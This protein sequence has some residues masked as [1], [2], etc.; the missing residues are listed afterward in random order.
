MHFEFLVEE[1]SIEAALNNML[2]YILPSS[3]TYAIRVFQG[4]QDLLKK[5]PV[6]LSG[7]KRWIPEDYRIVI[8]VD[9]D[10]DDCLRLKRKLE[11]IALE[12]QFTTKSSVP[13]FD[14]FQVLNR[15]VI[16]ELESWFFGNRRAI[17]TAYPKISNNFVN[18]PRIINPD[19][20]SD[21]WKKLE[22]VLQRYRYYPQGMPKIEVA[23]NISLHMDPERNCSPSFQVFRRGLDA[24][25]LQG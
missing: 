14:S 18:K 8:L 24:I 3:V 22:K 6:H 5:L 11:E 7:Y 20:I 1:P 9:R 19:D 23:Q 12:A 2:P 21:P 15:I 25:L 13:R 17:K 16:E 10:N 4:K